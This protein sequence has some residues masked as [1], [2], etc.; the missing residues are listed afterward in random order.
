MQHEGM[1]VYEG[2]FGTIEARTDML[3]TTTMGPVPDRSWRYVDRAGH[4]HEWD[5]AGYL[6]LAW[7]TTGEPAWCDECGD[8]EPAPGR[9]ECL[10]CAE[11][12][13]PGSFSSPAFR[14]YTPGRT[15]YLL[16]GS[17]VD[18]EIARR[19]LSRLRKPDDPGDLVDK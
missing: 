17:P 3:D 4:V 2:D 18:P 12:I 16:N 6:T 1:A 8:W 11:P 15:E 7:V 5:A 13:E 10:L 19:L 9:Y 14:T